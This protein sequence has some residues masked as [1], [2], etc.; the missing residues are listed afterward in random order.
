MPLVVSRRMSSHLFELPAKVF[1]ILIS[2]PGSDFSN[3]LCVL[4]Q[5]FLCHTNSAID[6][7]I[8]AG[9]PKRFFVDVL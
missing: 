6:N 5:V 2:A 4:N 3:A 1:H 7:V 9:D 8:H